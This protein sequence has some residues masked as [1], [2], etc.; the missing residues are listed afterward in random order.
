M[1]HLVVQLTRSEV[2]IDDLSN[3]LICDPLNSECP[4]Y[5]YCQEWKVA[6]YKKTISTCV[7]DFGGY[8]DPCYFDYDTEA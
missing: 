5:C 6:G 4:D 3:E 2:T 1:I 8:C 7:S